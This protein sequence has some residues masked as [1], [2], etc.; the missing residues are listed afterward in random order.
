MNCLGLGGRELAGVEVGDVAL[1]FDN[2]ASNFTMVE[3]E[4]M[5]FSTLSKLLK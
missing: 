5:R 3:N 4:N 2:T 1:I